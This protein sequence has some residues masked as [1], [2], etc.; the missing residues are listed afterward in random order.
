MLVNFL[1][2][3][4]QHVAPIT[5]E[6]KTILKKV[7][8]ISIRPGTRRSS[9]RYRCILIINPRLKLVQLPIKVRCF[10]LLIYYCSIVG[11]A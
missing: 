8:G 4:H 1:E 3:F 11:G 10:Q 5:E 7:T 9:G 6:R 2:N